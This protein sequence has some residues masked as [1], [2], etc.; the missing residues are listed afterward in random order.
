MNEDLQ[1]R[2]TGEA[3][4]LIENL[5]HEILELE[6]DPLNSDSIQE[7]FRVMHTLKGAAAMFGFERIGEITH[8]LEN[9]Y[10]DIRDNRFNVN[11]DVI[12][13]TLDTI[14]ILK[15]LLEKKENLGKKEQNNFNILV[16]KIIEIYESNSEDKIED[17][18]ESV[19][20]TLQKRTPVAGNA[21]RNLYYIIYHP[22]KEVYVRGANPYSVFQDLTESGK[23]YCI[24][25]VTSDEI[26][27][28]KPVKKF[29]KEWEIFYHSDSPRDELDFIFMFFTEKEYQV[30][31]V[32]RKKPD[33]NFAF[34]QEYVKRHPE[35][36]ALKN[37]REI[38]RIIGIND[39]D[40][41][42]SSNEAQENEN[43]EIKTD[44]STNPRIMSSGKISSIKV[45]SLKLDELINLVGELVITNSHL[46]YLAS[47]INNMELKKAIS[48][49][50]KL[51]KNLR[52]NTLELRLIPISILTTKFQRLVRDLSKKLGKQVDFV[53]EG[54]ETELDSNIINSLDGPLMHIIRNGIDHGIETP[55][56][57]KKRNKSQQGIIRLSAYYSGANVFISVQDDGR[58]IDTEYVRNKAVRAGIIPSTAKLGKKDIYD[59][60][61]IP[62]FSTAENLTDVSGRGVGLDVVKKSII[63]LRG[64]VEIDSE[65]NLGTSFTLKLPLTLSII[66]TLLVQINQ[67]P[68]LIP[69]SSIES[70]HKRLHTSLF[71][72]QNKRIEYQNELIP[73]LYLREEFQ[74]GGEPP[75]IEN[76]IIINLN[77]KYY[78]LVVDKVMGEHQ[79]VVKPISYLNKNQEYFSGASVLGNGQLALI[80]D[81]NQIL[82]RR[83]ENYVNI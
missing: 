65:K 39:E 38:L 82:S 31:P 44:D 47:D 36:H 40:S 13:V 23:V 5:E 28:H 21:G 67:K 52:D 75:E 74:L 42:S 33:S 11:H 64:E 60:I 70:C 69:L 4:D 77:E 51:S 17:K 61:F 68:Y 25:D 41:A 57:R 58:G 9:I 34:K 62:G 45:S 1:N 8:H 80:L 20:Q 73:F 12:N 66:D 49:V 46:S 50:E 76:I 6:K 3:R 37:V 7:I 81:I 35:D 72:D 79:A 14:D 27:N 18:S 29:N 22:D 56:E 53:A 55:E 32:D 16:Q 71:K 78:A 2:F 26:E 10:D 59:L 43:K 19:P 48:R 63:D 30:I 54:T 83:K 24:P 15:L